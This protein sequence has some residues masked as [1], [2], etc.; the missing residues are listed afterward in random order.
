[1]QPV[2][3]HA[4]MTVFVGPMMAGKTMALISAY[5]AAPAD[6]RIAIKPAMDTRYSITDI[7]SHKG[8]HI[9]A[10]P[11]HNLQTVV[12]VVGAN[13]SVFI[14]EG[15]F[16]MDLGC[17][18]QE[19]LAMGKSVFVAGLAATARQVPWKSMSDALA[20]AD[21]IVHITAVCQIC[22]EAE[23]AHTML[24]EPAPSQ[25]GI[26]QEIKI[27]GGDIYASACRQCLQKKGHK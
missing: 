4:Q 26:I 18:C 19:L 2:G 1:M 24:R 13:D 25:T 22:H 8:H 20:I 3:G 11:L 5:M 14:D 23:A 7:V 9:P 27:G 16:F 15:Q 12:D 21:K 6:S 17:K 10:V